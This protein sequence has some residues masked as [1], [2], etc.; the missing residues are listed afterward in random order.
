MPSEKRLSL[1]KRIEEL[2]GSHVIC[3]LTSLRP[4]VPGMIA[5]DAVRVFF[6]HLALLP[7]RPVEKLEVFLVSNGGISTVPWRL[8]S[9]LREYAKEFNVLVPYRA[10]SAATL[11]ALGADEIVMHQ[12]GELGPIDPTVSNEFNPTDPH[13]GARI[14]I[15]VEDVTAYIGFVK[16]TVGITHEDELVKALEVLA[17]KVHPLALGNVER[18]LSQSRMTARKIMRT[19]MD[20]GDKHKIDEIVENMASKQPRYTA[21]Q[22]RRAT[23]GAGR[24]GERHS[25]AWFHLPL[26]PAMGVR[27][28]PA[29]SHPNPSPLGPRVS[30][31]LG[32][33]G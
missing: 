1:I 27:I 3:Y 31:G 14:G 9:F 20:E 13:T 25:G 16:S 10:Y 15:S 11:L 18:F 4:N 30:Y 19:H 8:V 5:D 2:W 29:A 24:G 33:R 17:D 12:F 23:V 22:P 28:I 32:G 7:S 26:H 6:D 21:P